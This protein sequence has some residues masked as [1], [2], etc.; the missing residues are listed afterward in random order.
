MFHKK[1]IFITD[2]TE[3]PYPDF[4][5]P[6]LL[7]FDFFVYIHNYSHH[8]YSQLSRDKF[9]DLIGNQHFRYMPSHFQQQRSS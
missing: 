7:E 8:N 6:L 1:T 2:G 4:L 3:F 9:T 5:D